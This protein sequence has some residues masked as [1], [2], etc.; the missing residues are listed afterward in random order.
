LI[1]ESRQGLAPAE[2]NLNRAG[3]LSALRLWDLAML[4]YDTFMM[5][6]LLF[7]G[8][9]HAQAIALRC[10]DLALRL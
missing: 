10:N 1:Y 8:T 5:L 6:E 9:D 3:E 7:Y 2:L 4:V